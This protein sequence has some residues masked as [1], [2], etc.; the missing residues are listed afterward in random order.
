[1]PLQ[2]AQDTSDLRIWSRLTPARAQTSLETAPVSNW[3][4]MGRGPL[5]FS[6][7]ISQE[8]AVIPP[9]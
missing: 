9:R 1:M 2:V 6:Y 4:N 3:P 5:D 7:P 8:G